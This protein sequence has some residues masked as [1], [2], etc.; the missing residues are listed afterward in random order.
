MIKI[1]TPEEIARM[2]VAGRMV[3]KV[4]DSV[5]AK[6][7]PGVTTQELDDYARELIREMG[8][9]GSFYGYHGYPA[10]LCVSINEEVVHGIPGKRIIQNGDIVSVDQGVTYD[11]FVGDT[12][13]TVAVGDVD[14][15]A[16][17][18]VRVTEASLYAGIEKAVEGNRLGDVSHAIQKTAEAAGFSV[19]RKFVG[20][21]IG[22]EMHEDPQIPNFGPAGRGP[23]LRAGMVLAIE[24]MINLGGFGVKVL[25]DGWTA[26]TKDGK[27]SA[28][29]EH[30]VAVGKDRPEI[31]TLSGDE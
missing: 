25:N 14:E 26:V 12:A 29:W 27:P 24:P 21:G 2:R 17:E 9:I 31:L 11:G 15:R 7:A 6:I 4:R 13:I 23:M 16:V 22:R 28:H 30:T 20:H 8:G 1:K 3:A 18:L 5:A 10:H 19:V